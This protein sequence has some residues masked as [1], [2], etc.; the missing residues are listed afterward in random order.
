MYLSK[1][2]SWPI[3]TLKRITFN[4][5]VQMV[6]CIGF[7]FVCFAFF[8][9]STFLPVKIWQASECIPSQS[10]SACCWPERHTYMNTHTHTRW[11]GSL[12]SLPHAYHQAAGM[13]ASCTAL[14]GQ[15]ENHRACLWS[16]ANYSSL[17][18]QKAKAEKKNLLPIM[19]Q[20]QTS[21]ERRRKQEEETEIDL[22]RV[23]GLRR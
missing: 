23:W 10:A 13:A 19:R 20:T 21:V 16:H 17:K 5:K 6:L 4:S 22:A 3:K 9:L 14:L 1:I 8:F 2:G 18:K 12:V 7:F 11:P 15:P